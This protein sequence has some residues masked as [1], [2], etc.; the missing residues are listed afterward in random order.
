MNPRH[1][2]FFDKLRALLG[3]Y[4]VEINDG[5]GEHDCLVISFEATNG[6]IHRSWYTSGDVLRHTSIFEPLQ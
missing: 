4:S 2:E 1:E 5:L 3:E 6:Q